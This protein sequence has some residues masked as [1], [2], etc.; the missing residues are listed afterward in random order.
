MMKSTRAK[1]IAA[2]MIGAAAAA[3]LEMRSASPR[4]PAPEGPLVL[5]GLFVGPSA[6]SDAMVIATLSSELADQIEWDGNQSD[7]ML[8]SGVALDSLRTR[9][10]EFRCRGESIGDRQP[11]V[12]AA[13]HAYL[14]DVVGESGG[15]IDAA[16][17]RKWI[18]AYRT[19]SRAATDAAK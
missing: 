13:V 6:G 17:R 18:E 14:D 12:R 11:R 9:A 10:R 2:L 15:P 16:Q 5:R 7:P 3:F 4:P 8:K 19:I 1:L